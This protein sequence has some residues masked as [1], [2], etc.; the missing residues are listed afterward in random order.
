MT[1]QVGLAFT[2]GALAGIVVA[3]VW[4]WWQLASGRRRVRSIDEVKA[5]VSR[6]SFF[7]VFAGL[8]AAWACW[9]PTYGLVHMGLPREF[10]QRH[11]VYCDGVKL[12]HCFAADDRQGWA[13]V[14]PPDLLLSRA[15]AVYIDGHLRPAFAARTASASSEWA[16]LRHEIVTGRIEIREVAR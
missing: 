13:L 4:V 14:V 9:R 8:L 6:R 3:L 5:A 12:A 10:T 2:S 1:I 16:T 15:R 7:A 11:E